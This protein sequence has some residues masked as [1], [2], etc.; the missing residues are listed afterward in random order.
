MTHDPLDPSDLTAGKH[1][2]PKSQRPSTLRPKGGPRTTLD[3]GASATEHLSVMPKK[4]RKHDPYAVRLED[5]QGYPPALQDMARLVGAMEK[6][7]AAE[8]RGRKP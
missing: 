7:R 4:T 6:R 3:K 5:V 1:Q 2:N 8:K